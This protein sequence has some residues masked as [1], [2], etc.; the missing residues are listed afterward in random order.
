MGRKRNLKE[1]VDLMEELVR[2]FRILNEWQMCVAE[3]VM[4]ELGRIQKIRAKSS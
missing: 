1:R 2:N 4:L 3:C